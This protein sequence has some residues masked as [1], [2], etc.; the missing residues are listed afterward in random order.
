MASGR[1]RLLGGA[2]GRHERTSWA[3]RDPGLCPYSLAPPVEA[4]LEHQWNRGLQALDS[5]EVDRGPVRSEFIY[6]FIYKLS[7]YSKVSVKK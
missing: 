3:R 2:L 1:R 6:K 7:L 4:N 5:R